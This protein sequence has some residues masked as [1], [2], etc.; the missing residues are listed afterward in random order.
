M[1]YLSLPPEQP[2]TFD[3][4]AQGLIQ[5]EENISKW[6]SEGGRDMREELL[7]I[8][9]EVGAE[10]ILSASD[11]SQHYYALYAK[12]DKG[13]DR[14]LGEIVDPRGFTRGFNIAP[15]EGLQVSND[16]T[17]YIVKQ[18]ER[19]GDVSR[20]QKITA[21]IPNSQDKSEPIEIDLGYWHR[22][23]STWEIGNYPL[24]QLYARVLG[25]TQRRP[26]FLNNVVAPLVAIQFSRLDDSVK[27]SL[28]NELL[29][30]KASSPKERRKA[31]DTTMGFVAME[32]L[33]SRE[34]RPPEVADI[35]QGMTPTQYFLYLYGTFQRTPYDV[36]SEYMS[37]AA[38]LLNSIL[39]NVET[40]HNIQDPERMI[41]ILNSELFYDCLRQMAR[42]SNGVLQSSVNNPELNGVPI[43]DISGENNQLTLNP[44]FHDAIRSR[45]IDSN[46]RAT[47]AL[48]RSAANDFGSL[49]GTGGPTRFHSDTFTSGCPVVNRN[50]KLRYLTEEQ[51]HDLATATY[52]GERIAVIDPVTNSAEIIIDPY[53]IVIDWLTFALRW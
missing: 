46:R 35:S 36:A 20:E 13:P 40:H 25:G 52:K 47:E 7:H 6:Y 5:T 30:A 23:S 29:Y 4:L 42:T 34:G 44:L 19:K 27:T 15:R 10:V 14:Y 24:S 26:E 11:R 48:Q 1:D 18:R 21:R 53:K 38:D 28:T 3:L 45:Y 33:T 41:E 32:S 2:N 39:E 31:F 37:T 9:K 12:M 8:L 51:V 22:I 49:L 50:I 43:F 17:S 16:T